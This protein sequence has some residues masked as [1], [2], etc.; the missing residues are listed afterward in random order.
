MRPDALERAGEAARVAE[1]D[2]A[3]EIAVGGENVDAGFA[4]CQDRRGEIGV[5]PAQRKVNGLRLIRRADA[6][7]ETG[8]ALRIDVGDQ[9]PVAAAAKLRRQIDRHRRLAGT[10]F[11]VGDGQ[12]FRV[13]PI[14]PSACRSSEA[15]QAIR[16][17][18]NSPSYKCHVGDLKLSTVS[19]PANM[20][21]AGMSG[22]VARRFTPRSRALA[23]LPRTRAG[24]LHAGSSTPAA[25]ARPHS[26]DD[27]ISGR[28]HYPPWNPKV[29][30]LQFV[31]QAPRGL[32][33]DLKTTGDGVEGHKI[34][35]QASK[36]RPCPNVSA[37]SM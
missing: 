21:E 19:A 2:L 25:A 5:R 12:E 33:N 26:Y 9:H 13:H 29:A 1:A 36:L 6:K 37:R 4:G 34:I 28:S 16:R 27:R 10:A 18:D 15:A 8:V 24:Y 3:I 20:G 11:L 30:R 14:S 31:R 7:A 35:A 23:R 32:G 22:T 17:I